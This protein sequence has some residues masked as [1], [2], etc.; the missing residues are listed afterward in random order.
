MPEEHYPIHDLE[1]AA[2]VRAL[3][4]WRYYLMEKRC[5]LYNGS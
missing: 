5:G 3:K 2:M 1:L 4:I